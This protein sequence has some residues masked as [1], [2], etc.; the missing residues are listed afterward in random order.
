[1]DRQLVDLTCI[2]TVLVIKMF[3]PLTQPM[4]LLY[5]HSVWRDQT[6]EEKQLYCPLPHWTHLGAAVA[7]HWTSQTL[8]Q[9]SH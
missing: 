5:Q 6:Q 9:A 3:F 2:S 8:I 1:M 7:Q 4:P